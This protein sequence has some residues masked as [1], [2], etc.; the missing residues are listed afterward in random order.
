VPNDQQDWTSVVARPQKQLA[1]SPWTYNSGGDTKVFTLAPDTSILG[2]LLG[3]SGNVTLL[4]VTGVTSGIVYLSVNPQAVKFPP[5]FYT[6]IHSAVDPTVSV[7]VVSTVSN[8]IYL[9]SIPDPVAAIATAQNPAPWQAPNNPP[10]Q[11]SF[12]NPGVGANITVIPAPV[13]GQAIW[14]H[15]MAWEWNG[16]DANMFGYWQTSD[17]TPVHGDTVQKDTAM[18]SVNFHGAKLGDGLALQFHQAGTTA[19]NTVFAQGS[20]TYA[21][22]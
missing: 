2:L 21:V 14:L 9:S 22:E 8:K 16:T 15:Q 1:G 13:N 6:I 20:I 18:R 5:Y 3:D 17:G 10:A 11:V 4:T 12:G 19:I 7:S